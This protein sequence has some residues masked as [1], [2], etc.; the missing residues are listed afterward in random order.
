LFILLGIRVF[1]ELVNKI[2]FRVVIK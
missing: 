2:N 1:V